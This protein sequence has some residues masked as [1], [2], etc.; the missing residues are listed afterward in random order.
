METQRN[1]SVRSS[2]SLLGGALLLLGTPAAADVELGHAR[3]SGS[4]EV[5]GRTTLGDDD[6][7]KFLEYRDLSE[8]AFGGFDFLAEDQ[9]GSFFLRGSAFNPGYDDQRYSLEGGRYGQFKVN[10]FYGELPHVYSTDAMSLYVRGEGDDDFMLPSGVQSAIAGAADSSAA[11]ENELQNAW[12]AALGIRWIEGR[13]G[14]ELQATEHLS[15]HSGYRVQ[16]KHGSR[17]FAIDIG[18]PGGTFF[19]IPGS[20][21]ETIHEVTAGAEWAQSSFNLGLDYRGSFY[22]NDLKSLTADNPLSDVDADGDPSRVRSSLD[23]D[24][25]AHQITLSGGSVLPVGFPA[26]VAASLSYGM[27]YQ[28][29]DFLPHTIN[30]A[31]TTSLP[32]DSLDGKVR[33]IVGNFLLSAR[34]LDVLDLSLRYHAYDYDNRS[35]TVTF[36]EHVVNDTSHTEV[37]DNEPITSV[38]NDYTK[39]SAELDGALHVC[40]CATAHLGYGWDYWH[41]SDDRQVKNLHEHGP[42][43]KLDLRLGPMASVQT[44]YRFRMREGSDYHT[45][46]FFDAHLDPVSAA[47]TRSVG[48]TQLLRKFDQADRKLHDFRTLLRV[49]PIDT[50]ELTASGGY[51]LADY[52]SSPFGLTSEQRWNTG[53]DGWVQPCPRFGAGIHYAYEE[54]EYEQSSRWRTRGFVP[55]IVLVDDPLNNWDSMTTDR[56]HTGGVDF[57]FVLVPERLDLDL[58]YLIHWGREKT[59]A[60]G[61]AG[62]VASGASTVDGGNA[63]NFPE[64][65]E[66]LQAVTATL[67]L[68]VT[69]MLTLKAQYRFEDYHVDD[70]RSDIGVFEAGSDL[71]GN[72]VASPSEDV[73]L[74]D[75]IDDYQAHVI[76]LSAVVHF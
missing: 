13:A 62:F 38:P 63:V 10:L 24:N 64:V 52:G 74:G 28:D 76:G 59:K 36:D 54:I 5:G 71:N 68:H 70:F 8:G 2:L 46:A 61:P 35:D 41:R 50:V 67:Q 3:V 58:G 39:H 40:D 55:P 11:L 56:F 15:L 32:Q 9:Q 66:R 42:N 30:T 73:F 57:L 26:H 45:F 19:T 47:G 33:T 43:A 22:E 4:V 17:A 34:P 12:P 65:E 6:E 20:V 7:A 49:T 23:P 14:F 53:L 29:Q 37:A 21:D 44:S 60:V 27:R 69:E 25:S 18:N 16:D 51:W 48:E 75:R 1:R 31:F 72:G